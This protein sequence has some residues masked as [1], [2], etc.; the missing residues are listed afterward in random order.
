MKSNDTNRAQIHLNI[1]N[2]QLP[3]FVNSSSIQSV[4]NLLEDV[5]SDLKNN[6]MDN[7]LIYLNLVKQQLIPN[8][9]NTSTTPSSSVSKTM[10]TG[11]QNARFYHLCLCMLKGVILLCTLKNG[12]TYK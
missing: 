5:A 3:T 6:D 2:Q 9:S 10:P 4:K 11:K 1:L 8:G 7:A 12:F